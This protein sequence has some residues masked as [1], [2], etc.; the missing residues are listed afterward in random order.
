MGKI[1]TIHSFRMFSFSRKWLLSLLAVCAVCVVEAQNVLLTLT[2]RKGETVKDFIEKVER[3]SGY[4]FA[5]N[6]N[7]ID[8]HRE[9]NVKAVNEEVISLVNRVLAE[10]QIMAELNGKRIILRQKPRQETTVEADSRQSVSGVV[11]SADGEPVIGASVIVKGQNRGVATG[12]DGSFSIEAA[13]DQSLQISFLGYAPV[14]I[15]VGSKTHLEITM[16][17]DAKILDDVV[18]IGYGVQKKVNLTGSVSVVSSKDIASRP[19]SSISTGLQGMLPG[20]SVVNFSGQPGQDKT[21]IRIR[22]VGT[23]GNS[24]P[25]V[26]VDGVEGEISSLNP[27]DIESVSV[28]KDAASASI[29]GARG[30]NGVILVT[31]RKLGKETS[32]RVN[33]DAYVGFQKPIRLP[34][35]CDAITYMQ[36]ENEARENVGMSPTW[37]QQHFDA[38]MNGTDPNTYADTDWIGNVVKKSALQQNYAASVVGSVGNSGYRLSYRYFDQDGL[39]AGNTTGEQRHNIRYKMDSK[40]AKIITLSSNVGYTLRKIHAPQGS[41]TNGGGAIYNAMRIAP[42]APIYYTDGSWAYGGGNTNPVAVLRDGGYDDTRSEEFTLQEGLKIQLHKGWSVSAT[43]NYT[44]LNSFKNSLAK[45][46]TFTNPDTGVVEYEYNNPN[47]ISNRYLKRSKHTLILQTDFDY[48]FGRH[49]ISGVLG[50]EQEEFKERMF[51]ASRSNLSTE[52]DPS[53][54][55]GDPATVGNDASA[56]EWALRSGFGRLNYNFDERYLFEVNL[57]YDLSS[58]FHKSNRGGWF[59]SFSFGWR[60]SEE[61]FMKSARKVLD[62]LKL[63]VSYGMLGNQ[64][65]G[66]SNY[67]YL[68][69]LS[70]ISK[71]DHSLIGTAPTVAYVQ[72]LLANPNLK[73][74]K[75][76]MLDFGLDVALFSN[77]LTMTFDWYDKNTDRTLLKRTYPSQIGMAWP[78]ENLGSV[79]NRGWELDLNWQDRR[80]S[81]TYGLGFNLSDVKNKITSLGGTAADLSGSMIRRVGDPIDAFYGYICSGLMTPEDFD[82]HIGNKYVNPNIPVQA[83]NQYQPGDLKYVDISGP[84]GVPDGIISPEYD[85]VVIGSNVPRFN[86]TLRGNLGWKNFDFSFMLQGVGK[87]DGYL[88]GSARHAFQ[89]NAGY[90]QRVHTDRYHVVNN[91]NPHASYPRLTYGNDYN[92]RQLSTFWLEDAS[93]LRLKNIQLGYTI[94]KRLLQRAHISNCRLYVSIDNLF[95]KSDYFYAYDPETPSNNR[96]GYYPQVKTFVFGVN[97]SFQ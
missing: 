65:V 1:Y 76:K 82:G 50:M 14:E 93:Y 6:N 62:N 68:A 90:P 69:A 7:E 10:Q 20:V 70:A 29:Y 15:E 24:N 60:L 11:R 97:I 22:G 36:L 3:K 56:A 12:V 67:P 95:T 64:Y 57:R 88:S 13:P 72:T 43:Y 77:R 59:P 4:T 89:D 40:I 83:G 30:A 61:Q 96:G 18:V 8:L 54:N 34:E 25:L 66:S 5:Y 85:R 23:W 33:F 42:Y 73:W 2:L 19:M 21:S 44:S 45:T 31:T 38:V 86:Y 81:V 58:R 35:M 80:G 41:L 49:T 84:D 28:L 78:E 75:I 9:V 47:S 53:L 87:C 37:Q 16:E 17:S 39:T 32:P 46:I 79:R 55:L 92:H 51:S 27:D 74:E 52:K 48:T 94:P 91:P 63:R 26:L 71:G